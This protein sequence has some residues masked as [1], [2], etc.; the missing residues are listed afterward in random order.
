MRFLR[1]PVLMF[2]FLLLNFFNLSYVLLLLMAMAGRMV[3]RVVTITA[4]TELG[5]GNSILITF[6]VLQ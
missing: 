5:T 6:A 1:G 2:W 3:F 4:P